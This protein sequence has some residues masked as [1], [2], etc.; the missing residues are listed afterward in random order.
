MNLGNSLLDIGKKRMDAPLG[1][2]RQYMT[3]IRVEF[4]IRLYLYQREP[5]PDTVDLRNEDSTFLFYLSDLS[6][7]GR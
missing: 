5:K 6:L 2:N 3:Y 7:V 1:C 4:F